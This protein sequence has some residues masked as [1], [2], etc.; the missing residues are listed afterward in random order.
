MAPP[1]FRKEAL[2]FDPSLMF[3][4]SQEE[5]CDWLSG[6]GGVVVPGVAVALPYLPPFV[7]T[8]S[9]LSAL[10]AAK[11]SLTNASLQLLRR[12]CEPRCP[13]ATPTPQGQAKET[14]GHPPDLPDP[15]GSEKQGNTAES[16]LWA[17]FILIGQSLT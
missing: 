16:F 4:E 7:S 13:Q 11:K 1:S 12:G 9:T 10:L 15:K 17:G 3:L 8:L 2:Q 14:P 5:V 6:R